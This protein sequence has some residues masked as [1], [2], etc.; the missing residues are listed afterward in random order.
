MWHTGSSSPD[1]LPSKFIKLAVKNIEALLLD[2]DGTLLDIEVSF[3]LDTMTRSMAVYFKD[4]LPVELF[5]SGLMGCIQELTN[6]PRADGETNEVGF[7]STFEELTGVDAIVARERFGSFY[8]EVF[9]GF[10]RHGAPVRYARELIDMAAEND[11]VLVLATTPIFPRVA[12]LERMRWGRISEEPFHLISDMETTQ[13]CKPQEEYYLEIAGALSIRPEKC[14]MVGNDSSHDM[15]AKEVGMKTFLAST[16]RVDRGGAVTAPD[17][18]G[19][20][21]QLGRLLG[22]W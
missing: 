4:L 14:L 12:I 20:L 3:F 17:A 16:H 22:F 6:N 8:Q 1:R 5:E 18:T 21:K 7:F 11:L 10:S 13:F 9:P 15:A 2:L 19:D